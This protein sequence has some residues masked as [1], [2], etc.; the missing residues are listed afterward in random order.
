MRIT[1]IEN[2]GCF[3]FNMA[4]ENMQDAAMLVRYATNVTQE[5]RETSTAVGKDGT[6][7]GYCVFGKRK[8]ASAYVTRAR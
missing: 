7:L 8:N 3:A 6:F 1:M 2:D 5:V 4:A